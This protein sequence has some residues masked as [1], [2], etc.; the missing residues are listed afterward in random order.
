MRRSYMIAILF[1]LLLAACAPQPAPTPPPAPTPTSPPSLTAT[2]AP[3]AAAMATEVLAPPPF[4]GLPLPTEREELFSSS[5]ACA[6][7]HTSMM[8][9]SDTD[10]SI[11]T[12]W[13]STMMANAARDPYWQASVRG[14]VLSNPALQTV[15]EDKCS[16]CHMPM[17]RFTIATEGGAGQA[18]DEGFGD[19]ENE[20]HIL[21]MDGVS[22][23]LCHQ[24][25]E[26]GF[27]EPSS[28]SAG[29]VID[30]EIPSGERL[31]FGP[32]LIDQTQAAAMQGASGFIPNQGPHIQQAELCATCHTLY[33]PY[34]DA[35]GQVVGEFPEQM[36]YFEWLSSDHAQTLV[37][38]D[39]HMPEAEGAVQTSITGGPPRSAFSQHVFVGGNAYMLRVFGA[40]GEELEVTASSENF[41]QKIEQLTDHLQNRTATIALEDVALSGSDLIASVV[42]E[43]R[44]GHKFPT[45]FP[46][47]RAWLHL[48]VLDADRHAIFESGAVSPDGSIFG[49]DNDADPSSYEPHYLM[50]DSQD[51][52]QIYESIMQT[53]EGDVTTTLLRGA[54][55]VKD[56]RLLPLGFAK[57][58]AQ[59][60]IAVQGQAEE[61]EDFLGGGDRVQYVI[62]VG[63]AQGPFTLTAELLFQSISYRWAQNLRQHEAPEP[64]RFLDYY[65][66]VP[67][68]PIIVASTTV[69]VGQ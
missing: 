41:E 66:A 57:T 45:G 21:A 36:A 69:E 55:Y 12:F 46:A 4:K 6:V 62:N 13:R 49:N 63:A 23:T 18:L 17:A 2:P 50:I 27:G 65:E 47:R 40:F 16:A 51:Q 34:V 1:T 60:D 44:A 38:Q 68:L 22:C 19:A 39:C 35:E 15:I 11:D 59:E 42:I 56:N 20:L 53:P 48:S 64:T 10:V 3:T 52:V 8:D 28:F 26:T 37:C 24:I 33:T 29:Y 61:D 32:N 31:I 30:T 67:N 9:E 43:S 58:Q 25:Q 7:C 5:G 54:Q 14:E